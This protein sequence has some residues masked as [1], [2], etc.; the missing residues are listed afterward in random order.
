MTANKTRCPFL[1]N[2][3]VSIDPANLT[4]PSTCQRCWIVNRQIL[5]FVTV[6][7]KSQ[8]PT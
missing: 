3:K 6:E 5:D 8:I 4:R 2:D 7:A 1:A